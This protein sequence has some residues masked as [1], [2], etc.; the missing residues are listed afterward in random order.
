MLSEEEGT[1]LR[2]EIA[3]ELFAHHYEHDDSEAFARLIDRFGDGRDD[4]LR[5]QV[6]KIHGLLGSLVD[7]QGWISKSR[8]RLLDGADKPM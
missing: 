2:S 1:L 4:G 5:Y 8:H 7:S 3:R 6:I